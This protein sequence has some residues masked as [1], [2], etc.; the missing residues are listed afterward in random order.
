MNYAYIRVNGVANSGEPTDSHFR[1]R[2]E[3]RRE[4][5]VMGG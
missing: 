3:K 2:Q 5:I 4:K 1:L